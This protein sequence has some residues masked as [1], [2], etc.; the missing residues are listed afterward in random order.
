[1]KSMITVAVSTMALSL[2][3]SGCLKP[4]ATHEGQGTGKPVQSAC[5]KKL[6][7]EDADDGDSQIILKDGRG[8][9]FDPRVLDAFFGRKEDIF[10]IQSRYRDNDS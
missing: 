2:L 3:L 8:T 6:M 10:E 5:D 4:P 1:M 9:H 7:I